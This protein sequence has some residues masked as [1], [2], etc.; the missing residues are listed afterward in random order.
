MHRS[1]FASPKRPPT[2][3]FT[4]PAEGI[5]VMNVYVF[6]EVNAA[7]ADRLRHVCAPHAVHFHDSSGIGPTPDEAFLA[8]EVALGCV[9]A[10][11]VAASSRLRWLQLD[12][13]GIDPYCRNDIA[14]KDICISNLRGFY[15]DPV[16]ESCLAGILALNRGIDHMVRLQA[17]RKWVGSAYR[18]HL[19]VLTQSKV[20]I[21][22]CGAIGSRLAGLLAPFGCRIWPFGSEWTEAT[23]DEAVAAAD[24]IAC[25]APETPRSQNVFDRRRIGLMKRDAILANLGRGSLID[26]DALR[27]ALE[28]N[29]IRGAYLDVTRTEPLPPDDPLWTAPNVIL[30]QHSSGGSVIEQDRKVEF[31]ARG[32]ER[33]ICNLPPVN[34]VRLDRGY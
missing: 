7:Q 1:R 4:Y 16:A 28:Q 24:V 14:S 15:A 25:I 18:S 17:E 32:F 3:Q 11:W 8:A 9:P 27:E 19:H 2:Q 33:Y 22:G 20:V 21:F 13:T 12:S 10:D 34:R 31:F 23:L 26:E 6:M 29:R 30:T 5:K